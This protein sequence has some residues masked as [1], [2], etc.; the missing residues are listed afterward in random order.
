MVRYI[1][2]CDI[3][4]ENGY[5]PA[6]IELIKSDDFESPEEEEAESGGCFNMKVK[7][8]GDEIEMRCVRVDFLKILRAMEDLS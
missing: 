3:L 6:E 8:N 7:S 2:N 1:I 5:I 4:S